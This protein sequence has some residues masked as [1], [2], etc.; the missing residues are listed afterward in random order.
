M[1]SLH[2]L[3]LRPETHHNQLRLAFE[4]IGFCERV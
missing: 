1:A 2:S 3:I 4:N